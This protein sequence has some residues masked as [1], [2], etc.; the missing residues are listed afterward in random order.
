VRF[1]GDTRP[2]VRV[3]LPGVGS[4]AGGPYYET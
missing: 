3:S 2:W 1:S 4:H